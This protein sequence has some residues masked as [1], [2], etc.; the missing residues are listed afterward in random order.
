[1]VGGQ[2]K[3]TR[4]YVFVLLHP[5]THPRPPPSVQLL[6]EMCVCVGVCVR[7]CMHTKGGI[8]S[9]LV[10]SPKPFIV[11]KFLCSCVSLSRTCTN[12]RTHTRIK[13]TVHRMLSLWAHLHPSV[14]MMNKSSVFRNHTHSSEMCKWEFPPVCVCVFLCM[15]VCVCVCACPYTLPNVYTVSP[16]YGQKIEW[17]LSSTT[18]LRCSLYWETPLTLSFLCSCKFIVLLCQFNPVNSQL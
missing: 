14:V 11:C 9:I 12:K 2:S 8:L 5:S 15:C 3:V 17:S 7:V 6:Q 16:N 4:S 13:N 10:N 18:Q 1:M